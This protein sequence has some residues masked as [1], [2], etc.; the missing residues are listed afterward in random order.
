MFGKKLCL[1]F[2]FFC[3]KKLFLSDLMS[4]KRAVVFLTLLLVAPLSMAKTFNVNS[5]L[6][7]P[8]ASLDD[9][10]CETASGVCTLRAAV[11]QLSALDDLG[12]S[13]ILLADSQYVLSYQ[14]PG[15]RAD[16]IEPLVF[17]CDCEKGSRVINVVGAFDG[18]K[19]LIKEGGRGR[20]V[21]IASNM[22][23]I[24]LGMTFQGG[25]IDIPPAAQG[26]P[27]G[28]GGG[29]FKIAPN[30][31]AAF[32]SVKFINN[33]SERDHGGAIHNRGKLNLKNVEFIG[34]KF[35][36][37]GESSQ[38]T[39]VIGA[40][41]AIY[42]NGNVMESDGYLKFIENE[43]NKGGAI[44]VTD[45][46]F[47][48]LGDGTGPQTEINFKGEIEFI[49]NKATYNSNDHN[50]FPRTAG[51]GGAIYDEGAR[52][53]MVSDPMTKRVSQ[54]FDGNTSTQSL[55]DA[56]IIY[57]EGESIYIRA[58]SDVDGL[59]VLANAIFFASSSSNARAQ[60][61]TNVDIDDI[62]FFGNVIAP[63][64]GNSCF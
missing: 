14:R 51:F 55:G 19:I 8:D 39:S 35:D 52:V 37:L 49:R 48:N 23:A 50:N 3:S 21:F 6:D 5:A 44:Y 43:A 27:G 60:C 40:G 32:H 9:G 45:T 10:L 59:F 64:G 36:H 24:F 7:E 13:F 47:R 38:S 54:K 33:T 61:A 30:A 25:H 53:A 28:G 31:S 16:K 34:N 22:K 11:E 15:G 20:H 62:R 63:D 57:G 42:H 2:N 29:S 4:V 26:Y 17:K 1:I 46:E 12:S 58:S 41:G 18:S 56:G